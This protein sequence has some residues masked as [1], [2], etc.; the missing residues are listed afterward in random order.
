MNHDYELAYYHWDYPDNLFWLWP[1]FHPP[2]EDH[3]DNFFCYSDENEEDAFQLE[4]AIQT[5][6]GHRDFAEV[7]KRTY[8]IHQLIYNKMPLIPLW[9]LDS[10]VAFHKDVEHPQTLDPLRLFADIEKWK[11]C[12]PDGALVRQAF[13]PDQTGSVQS[14]LPS[15]WKG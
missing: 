12:R 8:T 1:L 10:Y 5:A 9:Q 3:K 11:L 7:Q 14:R 13:Q 6:M 15:A 2:G 4:N